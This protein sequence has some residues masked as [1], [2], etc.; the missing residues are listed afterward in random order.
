MKHP[1]D[2]T[3]HSLR[4]RNKTEKFLLSGPVTYCKG[5]DPL[6]EQVNKVQ[7]HQDW[8]KRD[9]ILAGPKQ[10]TASDSHHSL[11]Y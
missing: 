8:N 6:Q 1:R 10:R 2:F 4:N 3:L 11:S 9:P 5:I 7:L